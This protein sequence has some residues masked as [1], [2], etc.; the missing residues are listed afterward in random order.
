MKSSDGVVSE[1]AGIQPNQRVRLTE[2]VQLQIRHRFDT[3]VVSDLQLSPS[4]S[5]EQ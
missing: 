5:A 3:V 4:L 1:E 2:V